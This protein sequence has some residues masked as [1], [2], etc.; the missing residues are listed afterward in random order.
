MST[1]T[2]FLNMMSSAV[3]VSK[4]EGISKMLCWFAVVI[5]KQCHV[6]ALTPN[7]K[8]KSKFPASHCVGKKATTLVQISDKED[9]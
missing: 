7:H 8:S 3:V 5:R 2:A 6:T 1:G 9:L 4:W